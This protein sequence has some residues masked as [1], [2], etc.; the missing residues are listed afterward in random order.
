MG[1]RL[2]GSASLPPAASSVSRCAA[3][4]TKGN[5][6]T[7]PSVAGGPCASSIVALRSRA[8]LRELREG[9]RYRRRIRQDVEH[10]APFERRTDDLL[11]K[12]GR[13]VD[14]A[15]SDAIVVRRRRCKA[16]GASLGHGFDGKFNRSVLSFD[17]SSI[18]DGATVTS[19]LKRHQKTEGALC[20]LLSLQGYARACKRSRRR[21][22]A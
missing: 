9:L 8:T 1:D 17:A 20:P 12:L 3:S 16:F 11:V 18:P 15:M 14:A 19:G 5:T 10:P 6:P 7:R 21:G 2:R 4:H 13:D 22:A